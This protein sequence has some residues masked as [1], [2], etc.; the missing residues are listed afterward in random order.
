VALKQC[1]SYVHRQKS[2]IVLLMW[3]YR[4]THYIYRK[5]LTLTHTSRTPLVSAVFTLNP[6]AIVNFYVQADIFLTRI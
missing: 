4:D 5:E 3:E 2:G 1:V 6:S